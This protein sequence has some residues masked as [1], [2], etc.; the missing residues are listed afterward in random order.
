MELRIVNPRPEYAPPSFAEPPATGYLHLA[1]AVEPTLGRTPFPRAGARKA[2]LLDRLK[3]LAAELRQ[4]DAVR[5]VTVYRAALLPPVPAAAVAHPARFDVVV[6][7]EA[8]SVDALDDVRSSEPYR[9]MVAEITEAASD[10][11][12]MAARCL[13]FL[14]DVDKSRQGL[15]L[16]N[17]FAAEDAEVATRV[18]GHLAGWYAAETGLDNSTLLAPIGAADYVFVNHARWDTGLL[19]FAVKQFRKSSFRSYVLANLRANETIAMPILYR[20]A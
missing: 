7:V 17:Y 12:E 19:G 3:V 5:G 8:E 15:F 11:H 4:L 18:W 1:A 6:L 2:A 13:R 14:G 10:V 16:F 20:K 9:R